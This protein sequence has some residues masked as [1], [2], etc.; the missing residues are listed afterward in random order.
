MSQGRRSRRLR[1]RTLDAP[2]HSEMLWGRGQCGGPFCDAQEWVGSGSSEANAAVLPSVRA[3]S[4]MGLCPKC[5]RGELFGRGERF[6]S[7]NH[8][9]LTAEFRGIGL[10]FL[11]RMAIC[12]R[13]S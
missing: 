9:R 2:E 12:V 10:A 7:R 13:A 11:L 4:L 8:G 5:S 6:T 1:A 3:I